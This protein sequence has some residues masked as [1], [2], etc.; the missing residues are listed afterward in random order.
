MPPHYDS[1]L[2]KLIV[3]DVD[4]P[5]A[6]ARCFRALGELE[7]DGVATTRELALDVLRSDAFVAGEYSTSFLTDAKDSLPALAAT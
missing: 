7:I 2:A 3:W 4:R 6:I 5:G 1:L